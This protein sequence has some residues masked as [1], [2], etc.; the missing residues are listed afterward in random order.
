MPG[1]HRW[2][3]CCLLSC[4]PSES[5]ADLSAKSYWRWC[6]RG[7][8]SSSTSHLGLAPQRAGPWPFYKLPTTSVLISL[9][10][11]NRGPQCLTKALP[12]PSSLLSIPSR[13]IPSPL[14]QVHTCPG[15]CCPCLLPAGNLHLFRA[16]PR[17]G[18]GGART[19]QWEC[20][21]TTPVSIAQSHGLHN[22]PLVSLLL[23][24]WFSLGTMRTGKC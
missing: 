21:A 19:G 23:K 17:A 1:G 10:T 7:V 2:S 8:P 14:V 11:G 3:L 22:A 4:Q 5:P 16:A 24:P 20:E 6:C 12:S 18:A 9:L 15:L 13:S